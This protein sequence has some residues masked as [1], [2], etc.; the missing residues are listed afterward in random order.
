MSLPIFRPSGCS[1][2]VR[3]RN[4]ARRTRSAGHDH[5]RLAPRPAIH[6]KG[7]VRSATVEEATR[8]VQ[9]R[10]ELPNQEGLFKPGMFAQISITHPMGEGL[11]VPTSAV[12]RTGERDIA[13]RVEPGDHFIPVA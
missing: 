12:L 3:V 9:V 5:C 13:Y 10:I 8:T 1:Q 11:L 7:P 6:W 4:S 2:G